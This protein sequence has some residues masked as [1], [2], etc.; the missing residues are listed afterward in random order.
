[1]SPHAA[2][3]LRSVLILSRVMQPS[4]PAF[5]FDLEPTHGESGLEPMERVS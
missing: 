4:R 5:C 3:V 1:M 2:R